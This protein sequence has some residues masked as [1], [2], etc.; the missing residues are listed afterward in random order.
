M[1]PPFCVR[2]PPDTDWNNALSRQK[3]Y[4]F[5]SPPSVWAEFL[6]IIHQKVRFFPLFS[7]LKI[8]KYVEI[9]KKL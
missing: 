5:Y 3:I 9:K 2:L 1:P 7:T 8:I 4:P 6:Y